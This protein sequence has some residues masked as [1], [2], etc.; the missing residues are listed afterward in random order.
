MGVNS[1]D[2]FSL[3]T[4]QLNPKSSSTAL[5]VGQYNTTLSVGDTLFSF[6]VSQA[7]IYP[8]RLVYWNYTGGG[9]L[10]WFSVITNST[11]TN[12][13]LINDT[14]TPGALNAYAVAKIAPP[15]ISTFLHSPAGLNFTITDDKSALAP[16]TL[17]VPVERHDHRGYDQQASREL[18][19]HGNLYCAGP[20]PGRRNEH[21][22]GSI[23]RQC[24][25]RQPGFGND[26]LRRTP[27]HR[28]AGGG[29]PGRPRR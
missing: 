19:Y 4:S 16:A 25:P 3:A 15:Y 9:G 20:L 11:S 17:Q 26:H 1:D 22:G 28:Y 12:Y 27:V 7:G 8:F 6:S 2:G 21:A 10:L 5:I 29:L 23:F 24:Q 18:R 13:V 14:N